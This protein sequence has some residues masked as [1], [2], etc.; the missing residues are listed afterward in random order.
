MKIERVKEL[1]KN[2]GR[3]DTNNSVSIPDK[4]VNI[5]VTT[6]DTVPVETLTE[7]PNTEELKKAI[8]E[9]GKIKV[10]SALAGAKVYI[11]EVV[12]IITK[13]KFAYDILKND[14]SVDVIAM[15]LYEKYKVYKNIIL[16][17]RGEN[18]ES[19]SK[20]EKVLKDN[21]IEYTK[22]D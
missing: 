16:E 18:E 17:L 22:L 9:K 4:K 21:N 7:F 11:D 15:V 3:N 20:I 10:Y 14:D 13:N 19:I 6:K 1:V 2:S 12:R 5:S 8:I